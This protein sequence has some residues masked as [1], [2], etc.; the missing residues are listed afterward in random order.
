[1]SMMV[2]DIAIFFVG[3]YLAKIAYGMMKSKKVNKMIL[4][5]GEM[6]K[7]KDEQAFVEYIAPRMMFFSVLTMIAAAIG[8]YFDA[9]N[10]QGYE[11]LLGV[12][13][14]LIALIIFSIQFKKSKK[15]FFKEY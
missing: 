4:P 10:A 14:F 3:I 7:C 13:V 2:M 12:C 9:M 8:W 1:M 15:Q 6:K 11:S 5:D